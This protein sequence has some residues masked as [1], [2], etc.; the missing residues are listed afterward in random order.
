MGLLSQAVAPSPVMRGACRCIVVAG[1]WSAKSTRTASIVG[2]V[3][4]VR[5][6]SLLSLNC[7]APKR[8][9]M[10]PSR[11]DQMVRDAAI[12]A[13]APANSALPAMVYSASGFSAPTS[14]ERTRGGKS[15]TVEIVYCKGLHSK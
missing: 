1:A 11:S 5:A 15:A 8:A 14:K 12:G 13:V 10:T 3:T 2:G 6:K 4:N 9:T 7:I